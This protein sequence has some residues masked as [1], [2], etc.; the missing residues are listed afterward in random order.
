MAPT[1]YS[2]TGVAEMVVAQ[3]LPGR[4]R[5][6]SARGSDPICPQG[7]LHHMPLTFLELRAELRK[8]QAE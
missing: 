8:Y 7:L 3:K 5:F 2:G 6:L 1:S 4:D